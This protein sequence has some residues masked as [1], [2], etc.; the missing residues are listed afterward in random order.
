MKRIPVLLVGPRRWTDPARGSLE[1]EADLQ[2]VAEAA[3]QAQAVAAVRA[4]RASVAVIDEEC[5]GSD[6]VPAL[7]ALRHAHARTRVL[8][9]TRDADD[10]Y[11]LE[12]VRSGG[13]GVIPEASLPSAAGKAVRAVAGGQVWLTRSQEGLILAAL[14]QFDAAA[15]TASSRIA[16]GR[17]TNRLGV[18]SLGS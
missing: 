4:H 8:V 6:P 12:I 11:A 2:V 18:G 16:R 5:L 3:D 15:I 1:T 7:S 17:A 14:R 13:H 9:V 10:A